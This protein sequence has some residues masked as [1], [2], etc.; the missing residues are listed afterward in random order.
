[1][2]ITLLRW[3]KLLITS[4][5]LSCTSQEADTASCQMVSFTCIASVRRCSK[6]PTATAVPTPKRAQ[7]AAA[8]AVASRAHRR[9]PIEI[10]WCFDVKR[11][12]YW[13]DRRSC[14][15]TTDGSLWLVSDWL[16][17]WMCSS[18]ADSLTVQVKL[19]HMAPYR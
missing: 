9:R 17:G 6:H 2:P 3:A 15:P 16:T 7:A 13:V 19:F 11:S 14:L 5:V 4:H 10:D 18:L 8:A 12:T 1:M